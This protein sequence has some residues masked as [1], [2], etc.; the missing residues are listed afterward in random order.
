MQK[1]FESELREIYDLYIDYYSNRNLNIV[2]LFDQDLTV[3]AGEAKEFISNKEQLKKEYQKNFF[4]APNPLKII[5]HNL[6]IQEIDSLVGIIN[7]VT[8]WHIPLKQDI[9][10]TFVRLVFVVNKR[11]NQIKIKHCSVSV[12]FGL[13]SEIEYF[14]LKEMEERNKILQDKFEIN[15]LELNDKYIIEQ[16]L[17][18]ENNSLLFLN[19]QKE[20]DILELELEKTRLDLKQKEED[21]L[22]YAINL[23][24]KN[25]C[26]NIIENNLDKLKNNKNEIIKNEVDNLL[27]TLR[28][29]LSIDKEWSNFQYKFNNFN[30]DFIKKLNSN[31]PNLTPTEINIISMLKLQMSHKDIAR[32]KYVTVSNIQNHIWRIRK[33]MNLNREINLVLFLM[34]F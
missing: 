5:T 18:I 8:T 11:E 4:E 12:P 28:S 7:S 29:N 2:D 25:E 20:K 19:I 17:L 3:I 9:F 30:P 21:L 14:P 32:L 1:S 22:Y 24:A 23:A 15:S 26:F 16:N 34:D 31:F 6:I 10:T 33:K 27:S 13:F